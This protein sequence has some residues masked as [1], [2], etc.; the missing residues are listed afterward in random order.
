MT[1]R[2]LN[3][4][5]PMIAGPVDSYIGPHHRND[6]NAILLD[7]RTSPLGAANVINHC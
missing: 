3:S 5:D 7:R 6:L 4:N 2:P 1:S